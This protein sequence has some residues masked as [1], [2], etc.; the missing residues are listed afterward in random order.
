MN[1]SNEH[2]RKPRQQEERD[3]RRRRGAGDY[4]AGQKLGVNEEFLDRKN[5]EYRWINDDGQRVQSLT[6]QDDWDLIDDPSKAGKED[7]DGLGTKVAKV[8]GRNDAGQPL[9]A[10]L[11]R[12][13][14]DWHE[15]DQRKKQEP[16][17][18]IDETIRRG[19]NNRS[20]SETAEL[21]R[22]GYVP[23]GAIS[24]RDGRRKD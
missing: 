15:E 9:Y 18:Q 13:R 21:S 24:M 20:A 1:D 5:F 17:D 3:R 11:A 19:T 12:K 8:V 6:V 10:Y 22:Y 16:L 23:E 14:R 7:V 2:G 4:L